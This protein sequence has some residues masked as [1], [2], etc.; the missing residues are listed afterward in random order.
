MAAIAGADNALI[1]HRAL[2]FFAADFKTLFVGVFFR[3][4]GVAEH[5]LQGRQLGFALFGFGQLGHKQGCGGGAAC[6][7]TGQ[8]RVIELRQAQGI[9]G[10]GQFFGLGVEAVPL[11]GGVGTKSGIVR[12]VGK[13]ILAIPFVIGQQAGLECDGLLP[14]AAIKFKTAALKTT[15]EVLVGKGEHGGGE[16]H[17][18]LALGRFAQA[19]PL[20][21]GLLVFRPLAQ[22]FC[23]HV[24]TF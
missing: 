21:D 7:P 18:M 6:I 8:Y 2:Y 14:R 19:Q 11:Y 24:G 17:R 3:A 22:E 5:L 4:D 15:H 12:H 1:H 20:I 9:G 16:I 10:G 23:H 13:Q